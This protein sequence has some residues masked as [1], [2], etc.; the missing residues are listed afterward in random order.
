[1]STTSDGMRAVHLGAGPRGEPVGMHELHASVVDHCADAV[2]MFARHRATL[3]LNRVAAAERRIERQRAAVRSLETDCIEH[4]GAWWER[5]ADS[6]D[7]AKAWSAVYLL[8]SLCGDAASEPV[9]A[10][11]EF[12]LDDGNQWT[13]AAEALALASP[14]D[15]MALGEALLSSPR[16]AACAVGLDVLARHGALSQDALRGHLACEH[17]PVRAAAVRA[18]SRMG[19]VTALASEIAACLASPSGEVA[20][21]AARALTIAGVQ[22]P[23]F[24]VQAGGPL[25]SVLGVRGV[26][27]LIMAGEDT[28]IGVFEHVLT[29]TPMTVPLLSA[30][31]RFGNVTAW[32]F[33]LHY[34]TEPELA[35]AAVAALRTLFGDLVPEGEASR[36]MAWKRAIGEAGFNPTVRYRR[37]RPWHPSTVLAEC[38]SDELSRF[39]VEQQIDELAARTQTEPCVDLGLW[40]LERRRGLAAFA[41]NAGTR[42]MRWRPG[43]WRS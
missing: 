37:G 31:A 30:V 2:A 8:A 22:E 24:N 4:I 25:T 39:E 14:G 43:A 7:P 19:S 5:S 15:S 21:E 26:E 36:Y 1:M 29:A 9:Q 3:P 42:G 20:W 35:D 17:G 33:L 13:A 6:G 28:D 34:L 11:L 16:P 40:E 38:T 10:A 32:S 23:Y 18:A 41:R 27:L 12:L